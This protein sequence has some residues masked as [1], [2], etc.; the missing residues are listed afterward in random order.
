MYER[1]QAFLKP[2]DIFV[3]D[4]AMT[5]LAMVPRMSNLPDRV[6]L[7]SQSSWGAIGWG[8]PEILGNCLADPSRRSIILA[9]EGGHQM[10]ANELGTFARYGAKP[11][12]LLANN[13]GYFGERVTNRYPDE[14]YN[15][16]VPWDFPA[17]AGAMGCKDW[18]LDTVTTLGELDE[19][20][21]K[22]STADTGVY[23]EIDIDPWEL[24]KGADDFYTLTGAFFG[25]KGRKWE[26]WIKE[27]AAKKK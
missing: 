18:Q 23:I 20:L 5:A 11:I 22:A 9:G 6:S 24:P 26:D 25:M 15:D 27:L 12:F 8:T 21:T 1:I 2:N 19:A 4:T 7:E 16:V 3:A 13:Q 17:V 14:S 10:T